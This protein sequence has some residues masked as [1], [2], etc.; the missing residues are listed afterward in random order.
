LNA[1]IQLL[2]KDN[3]IKIISE[4]KLLAFNNSTSF[5]DDGAKIPYQSMQGGI[6]NGA[7]SVDFTDAKLKL[8]VTPQ[9]TNDG[10]I[11]LD[12]E[13]SKD[14]PDFA[15]QVNGTPTIISKTLKTKVRVE[16]GGTAVLGGVYTSSSEGGT[17]GVPLI[18]KLPLIGGLF[19]SKIH[20]EKVTE[21][22][23]MIS[24]KIL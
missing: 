2:E 7:I 21:M 14:Q 4:P 10:K 13:I 9:I 15:N 18:S 6:V 17:T 16:D 23:V 8:A 5:I 12:V 3:Q 24:P 22:L 19:R 20:N 11:I 1:I